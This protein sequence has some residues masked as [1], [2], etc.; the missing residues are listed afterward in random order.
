A[1]R[2]L[3][4]RAWWALAVLVLVQAAGWSAIVASIS[5]AGWLGLGCALA[6]LLVGAWP[7][8]TRRTRLV[9]GAG[10]ALIICAAVTLRL[11][12]T[13][14]SVLG[15]RLAGLTA[16]EGRALLWQAALDIAERSPVCGAGLE[17]FQIAFCEVRTPAYWQKE[18]LVLPNHAHNQF[19]HILATQGILGA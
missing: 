15:Q 9:I 14:P 11:P 10:L 12:G 7:L 17:T 5:R 18:W 8:A 3:R 2:A 6:V 16:L 1:V 19:L 4:Q 13:W